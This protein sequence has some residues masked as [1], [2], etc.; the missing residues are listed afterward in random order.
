MTRLYCVDPAL[1]VT[2]INADNRLKLPASEVGQFA[3]ALASAVLRGVTLPAGAEAAVGRLSAAN[4]GAYGKWVHAVARDLKANRGRC[5]IMAGDRQPPWVHALAQ[6]LNAALGNIGR[7]VRYLPHGR[8]MLQPLASLAGPTGRE[9]KT[10]VIVGGNPLLNNPGDLQLGSVLTRIPTIVHHTLRPNE[11]S[12]LATWVVPAAHFLEA[13]GDWQASDGTLSIQQPLIAPLHDRAPSELEFLAHVVSASQQSGYALVRHTWQ[14]RVGS[15]GFGKRWRKWL[16]DGVVQADEPQAATPSFGWGMLAAAL[17]AQ[18]PSGRSGYELNFACDNSV[19]DGRYANN[20]WLQECPDPI[21]KLAWDNAACMNQRLAQSLGVKD[22]DLVS[23]GVD[24]RELKLAAFVT[25][26][27]ADKVVLLHL[28]YGAK[29]GTIAKGVGFDVN[30]LRNS[31]S[32]LIGIG[33][34]VTKAGGTYQLVSTQDYGSMIPTVASGVKVV[35]PKATKNKPRPIV[36]EATL[37][38]YRARPRFVDDV[39]MIKDK[40]LIKSLWETPQ[41]PVP[42]GAARVQEWGM[43]IDLSTCTGCSVCVVACQAENSVATVGKERVANGRELHWIRVDRY[44]V[45]SPEDPRVV[46]QPMPCQQCETAPCEQVCPV[47]ATARSEGGLNDMVYNRCIGTRYCSNNCPF[48][49]RRFNYFNFTKENDAQTPLMEM[50][51]NPDVTV[52]FR[53]VM[54]KCTYCV[55]RIQE[56]KIA[57]KRDRTDGLAPDGSITP[58]C[59][60]A[61]PSNAIVFGDVSDPGSAVAKAKEHNNR[62]YALFAELNIRPRTTYLARIRNPNSALV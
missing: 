17:Q 26:G 34:A 22:G 13:W 23:I 30:V 19:F 12:A 28:G 57:A 43:S 15:A 51:R 38:R 4:A 39:E 1:T 48:K 59:A 3:K 21:T 36:R 31:K 27:V 16:H 24:G 41:Y 62:T 33:A 47:T 44:F 46:T 14:Q 45:G 61:C 2:S 53:G 18:R 20:A 6:L 56:G 29:R 40:S 9:V 35:D 5:L 55:Q 32:P 7:T 49:V 10:L 58:A 60:Q 25:P 37:G 8:M 11:T 54:E 42:A 50:Q 52:R